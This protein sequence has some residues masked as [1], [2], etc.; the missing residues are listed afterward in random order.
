MVLASLEHDT[1]SALET[2]W[3]PPHPQL[4]WTRFPQPSA[5]QN[6]PPSPLKTLSEGHGGGY[7]VWRCAE[8]TDRCVQ[9][10]RMAVY[11]TVHSSSDCVHI[12]SIEQ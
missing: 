5:P 4:F 10:C 9:G 8:W 2:P 7:A 1:R 11:M 3:V 6:R 12:P